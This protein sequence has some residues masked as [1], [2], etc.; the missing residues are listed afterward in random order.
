[1]QI[2]GSMSSKPSSKDD[3]VRVYGQYTE[4]KR[5]N[6]TSTP[7]T[8]LPPINADF[9][10]Q[11]ADKHNM[12]KSTESL[13]M[14]RIAERKDETGNSSSPNNHNVNTDNTK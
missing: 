11:L 2:A 3:P 6:S 10:K 1:M 9:N 14:E 7:N 13:R 8:V 5:S 4:E 12:S